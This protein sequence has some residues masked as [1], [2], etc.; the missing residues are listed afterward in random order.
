[1]E[2]VARVPLPARKG[3]QAGG[4]LAFSWIPSDDG[5]FALVEFVARERSAF[6][7]VLNANR[8]DVRAFVRGPHTRDEIEAE[9]RKRLGLF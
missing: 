2:G 1:M 7:G 3:P 9:F 8:P 4:I 6:R 5:K